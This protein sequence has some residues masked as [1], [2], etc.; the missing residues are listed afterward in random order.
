MAVLIEAVNILVRNATIER[1]LPD[2]LLGWAR[3][4]PNSMYCTDGELFRIGFLCDSDAFA[5]VEE[6]IG[7]GFAAPTSEGSAEIALLAEGSGFAY[8]CDWLQLARVQIDGGTRVMAAL[9]RGSEVKGLAVP[10]NW[11]PG[12]LTRMSP[13]ERDQLEFL[14]TRDGSDVFRHK[15]TGQLLYSR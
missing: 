10:R 6:L 4:C 14:G 13:Q 5:F 9:I 1:R 15:E 2:G 11:K 12:S 3:L 7:L 8:P